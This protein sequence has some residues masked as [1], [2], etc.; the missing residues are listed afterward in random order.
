MGKPILWLMN[1]ALN[2]IAKLL[3]Y[4]IRSEAKEAFEHI[5]KNINYAPDC[6]GK[7]MDY[8]GEHSGFRFNTQFYQCQICRQV[9][10]LHNR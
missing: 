8:I 7:P 10:I 3:E 2:L 4:P 5:K 1:K 6:C 9:E